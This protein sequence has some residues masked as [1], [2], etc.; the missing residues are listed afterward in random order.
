MGKDKKLFLEKNNRHRIERFWSS[1][2]WKNRSRQYLQTKVPFGPVT[3]FATSEEQFIDLQQIVCAPCHRNKLV[4]D[5]CSFH[6]YFAS[7]F[8]FQCLCKFSKFGPLER[9]KFVNVVGNS[10]VNI[11]QWSCASF[12]DCY[13]FLSVISCKLLSRI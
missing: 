4:V 2:T 9:T 1:A 13:G 6:L 3:S 10:K 7:L 11:V 12:S 8:P 5:C